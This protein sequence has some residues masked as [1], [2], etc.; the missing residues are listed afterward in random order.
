MLRIALCDDQDVELQI[1]KLHLER[2]QQTRNCGALSIDCFTSSAELVGTL[3][4]DGRYD[5]FILDMV[6]P[7]Y[8]G[9]EVGRAIRAGGL[10]SAIIYITASPDFALSA[11]SVHPEQYLLKPLDAS[12]LYEALDAVI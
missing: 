5:L 6:M 10:E 2:Y 11:I 4:N 1:L 7:D 3:R 9:V 12:A 8:N